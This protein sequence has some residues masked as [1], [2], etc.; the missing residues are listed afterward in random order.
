MFAASTPGV[1]I[2]PIFLPITITRSPEMF[3]AST[4][5]VNFTFYEE[6]FC[7][8]VFLH[9]FNVLTYLSKGN[10]FIGV[11]CQNVN[12]YFWSSKQPSLL[13]QG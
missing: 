3:V 2:L 1:M 13:S 8:N 4:P 5:R 11:L 10:W 6:V 12:K 7:M 9:S